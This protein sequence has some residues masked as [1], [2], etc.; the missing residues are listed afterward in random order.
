MTPLVAAVAVLLV[1]WFAAGTIWNV[2]K[3]S[4]LMRWMQSGL[5]LIGARTTV[6]WL[7]SSVVQMTLGDTKAPFNAAGVVIFLEPRDL[8]WWPLSRARGRRDTLIVRGTLL[9][10]PA[11]ELELLE[12]ASW[13]ERDALP[14]I[15]GSWQT[16]DGKLRLHHDAPAALERGDA[17]LARA[18]AAGMQ[19]M[20]LS[21]RRAEPNFQLHVALPDPAKPAREFFDAVRALG[22]LAL[23]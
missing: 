5:P 21:V 15:P 20:R 14:R 18:Q 1:A 17:L 9:R 2:R 11:L 23:K 22:E 3:G 7:G 13:S 8:P 12:P 6:R 10:T 19:L 4:A 16:R